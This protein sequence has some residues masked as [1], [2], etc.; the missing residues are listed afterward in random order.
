MS[1]TANNNNPISDILLDIN[2]YNHDCTTHQQE[3]YAAKSAAT[4]IPISTIWYREHG[5][6]SA[7]ELAQKRQYLTPQEEKALTAFVLQS[8]RSGYYL[9]VR[10][11]RSL[12]A[13]IVAR[14]NGSSKPPSKN[15]PQHFYKRNPQIVPRTLKAIDDK[16]DKGTIFE[17]VEYWFCIIT[18]V[19]RRPDVLPEKCVQHG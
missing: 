13:T 19:L 17:K 12:A 8:A 5:R 4:N 16:R 11:L 9:P 6:R 2:A 10:S 1:T 14:R 3:T 15:W 18:P 7:D